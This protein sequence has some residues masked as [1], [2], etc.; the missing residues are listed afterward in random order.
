MDKEV[1]ESDRELRFDGEITRANI[2]NHA[3]RLFSESGYAGVS[4]RNITQS[5]GVHLGLVNYYF[6]TK[7]QLFNEVMVRRVEKMARSR[8]E[9]LRKIRIRENSPATLRRI[10]QAFIEPLIGETEEE[11]QELENYRRLIAIVANSKTW[12]ERIFKEHYDPAAIRFIE[13][14][15]QALPE[16]EDREIYWGFNFFLGSLTNT[17]AETGRVDRLSAGKCR[18]KDLD[19]GVKYLIEYTINAML[20]R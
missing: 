9:K 11:K 15:K 16:K 14:L 17:I 20:G 4:I 6:G 5:V 10:L 18:A 19:I 8:I 1:N 2:L 7:E 12:Q 13:V 3:E